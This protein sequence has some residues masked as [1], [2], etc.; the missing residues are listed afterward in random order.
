MREKIDQLLK[1]AKSLAKLNPFK[2]YELAEEALGIAKTHNYTLEIANAYYHLSYACRV[3]SDYVNGLSYALKSLEI[4]DDEENSLGK[5][6]VKNMIGI[7]YFYYGDYTSALESYSSAFELL[8]PM[9]NPNMKSSVLNNIGEIYREAKQYD[10]A[11]EYY[12]KALKVSLKAD[13]ALNASVMYINMSEIFYTKGNYEK[14]YEATKSSYDISLEHQDALSLA[15][16]ESQLGRLKVT[17]SKYQEAKELYISGLSRLSKV[18]NRFYTIDLLINF[19][20]LDELMDESPI[21][22]LTEALNHAIEIGSDS[23]TS[24]IYSHLS[25]YYERIGEFETALTYW[26]SYH[27][28]EKEVG[29][30][31]LSKKLEVLSLELKYSKVHSDAEKILITSNKFEREAYEAKKE[32]ERTKAENAKLLE[33]SVVDEL[34]QIYNR[35]GITKLL[36]EK[37]G[38]NENS[39]N[40]IMILDIDFFKRYNDNWGHVKGD[41][42]LYE[43]ARHLKELKYSDY[44]VGRYGGEE[45]L[46]YAKVGSLEE[47]KK[48][49]DNIC[50]IIRMLRIPY[51][52]NPDSEMITISLGGVVNNK[53]YTIKQSIEIADKNLYYIKETGR[54]RAEITT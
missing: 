31:N 51:D 53:S 54:N 43:I 18:N 40:L 33:V 13:L 4:Y 17:D 19:S 1:E 49:A 12:D 9:N 34:T 27:L 44:F 50:E 11:L 5:I 15:E 28:K 45:F 52:Q 25:A 22:H 47:G 2:S 23:K 3:M 38:E 36:K 35:R 26:K 21:I 8:E 48:I 46:C 10:L 24:I 42:C 39:Y 7:I 6:K 37:Y 20:K 30:N 16:A 32:L 29:L 14:A 41:E